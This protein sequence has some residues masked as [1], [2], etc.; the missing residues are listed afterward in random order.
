[1]KEEMIKTGEMVAEDPNSPTKYDIDHMN[2]EE[3][4]KYE[5]KKVQKE[6]LAKADLT[7]QEKLDGAQKIVK[8]IVK[9]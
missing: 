1:M 2:A 3:F 4:E 6:I 7:E 8:D 5:T 9:K